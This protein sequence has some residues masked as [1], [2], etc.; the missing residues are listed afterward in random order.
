ME[1][2]DGLAAVWAGVEDDAIAVIEPGGARNFGGLGKQMAQQRRLR[3]LGLRQ[4]RNVL[5]GNYQQMGGRLGAEIGEADTQLVLVDA[6]G[7]DAAGDDLAEETIGTHT[8]NLTPIYTDD[9]DQKQ[10]N[11]NS[12]RFLNVDRSVHHPL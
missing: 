1:V 11:A 4:R 3:R 10:E 5:P 7:R 2:V 9:T 8:E 6:L 12:H